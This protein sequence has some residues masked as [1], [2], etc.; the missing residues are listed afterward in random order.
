MTTVPALT[1]IQ[2]LAPT[3]TIMITHADGTTDRFSAS[4]IIPSDT[5]A[6]GNMQSVSSNAVFNSISNAVLPSF[7]QD[8]SRKD[9]LVVADMYA[10][11]WYSSSAA[12]RFA[13][14]RL[15]HINSENSPYGNGNTDFYYHMF[16]LADGNWVKLL[17]YDVRDSNLFQNTKVNGVWQGW[18]KIPQYK[19][20]ESGTGFTEQHCLN[21]NSFGSVTDVFI[22]G[23]G[24]LL[25]FSRF[26]SQLR[27]QGRSFRGTF[28]IEISNSQIFSYTLKN[29]FQNAAPS[30]ITFS[31]GTLYINNPWLFL[32]ENDF[33][34][35]NISW[36]TFWEYNFTA[37]LRNFANNTV[38]VSLSLTV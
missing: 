13:S 3:D 21:F 35:S 24:T 38:R 15:G 26:L 25:N 20:I 6:S 32:L 8:D 18:E 31:N 22:F 10:T 30:E 14:F 27:L 2:N 33:G 11:N 5:V 7:W 9:P 19:V 34:S 36:E 16:K 4:K 29:K 1:P 12:D 37:D 23:S 28:S 17:A